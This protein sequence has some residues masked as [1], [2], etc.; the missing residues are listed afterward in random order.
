MKSLNI[1][2]AIKYLGEDKYAVSLENAWYRRLL[3]R[4]GDGA[5]KSERIGRLFDPSPFQLPNVF[6][7]MADWLPKNSHRLLWIDHFEDGFPSQKHQF[8]NVLGEGLASDHLVENPAILLGP[9][10]D[11]LMD[12]TA[13]KYE[14]NVEAEALVV[15]CTLLSVGGWDA[16]L[17]TN[18]STD[19]VE[20]W[21]GNVLFYSENTEALNRATKIF[22]LYDLKTS[23]T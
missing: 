18:G 8:L 16:K 15:L 14:Q 4:V 2:E 5:D 21:E 13:G 1:T 6:L 3:H 23:W 9:L 11:D 19:Y 17:L 12:Q 20:F 10:S 22:D 7:S